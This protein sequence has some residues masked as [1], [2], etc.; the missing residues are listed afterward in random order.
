[1]T[2]GQPQVWISITR[3]GKLNFITNYAKTNPNYYAYGAVASILESI[4]YKNLVD[5]YEDVPYSQALQGASNSFRNY[6]KGSD[7]YV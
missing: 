3:P 6:D 2:N 4:C 7:I 1:M 5:A